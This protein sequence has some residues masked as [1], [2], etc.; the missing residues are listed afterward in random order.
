MT[1]INDNCITL[2]DG[3]TEI[4]RH[5][6]VQMLEDS[7]LKT[8]NDL[9]SINSMQLLQ[10]Q[11]IHNN[12]YLNLVVVG[13]QNSIIFVEDNRLANTASAHLSKVLS[14]AIKSKEV[15][16]FQN[17]A[18]TAWDI[19]Y[20]IL[21]ADHD[22]LSLL[23][24]HCKKSP[25]LEQQR[26]ISGILQVYS[27]YLT[28][29]DKA[30]RDKLTG[31]FNRETLDTEITKVLMQ[32]TTDSTG[33]A[34]EN[35]KRHSDDLTTWLGVVDIDH[36][37]FINDT[38][39]HLYGDEVLI[40]VA[41]LMMRSCVREDDIVYRYGGEEF[42]VMLKAT[43]EHNAMVAFDRLRQNVDKHEFPQVGNVAISIG[44][45]EVLGQQSATDVIG[46]ADNALYYAKNNGRNQTISY[47]ELLG[48][49]KI[50][51]TEHVDNRDIDLFI[52]EV[53]S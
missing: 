48:Q 10:M 38:Y 13:E 33:V 43:N 35:E 4:T 26:V 3:L 25:P 8:I 24:C 32:G 36:F 21:N 50:L 37:K 18:Q 5:H 34:I 30:Q 52:D 40:L 39:G 44:F 53:I 6:D 46:M 9:F 49:G 47:K 42:V 7:V 31:L 16:V 29:I 27:N 15:E 51:V 28:L 19:I 22:V 17:D 41:R 45:V 20:P 2:I 1:N 12:K 11:D 23:V 14:A